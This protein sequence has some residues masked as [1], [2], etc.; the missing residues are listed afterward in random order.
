[1]SYNR[2]KASFQTQI[3]LLENLVEELSANLIKTK[4]QIKLSEDFKEKIKEYNFT[5]ENTVLEITSDMMS[6]L[7][8]NKLI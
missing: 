4:Q 2:N 6:E 7:Y 5:L 3:E 1:M 8:S